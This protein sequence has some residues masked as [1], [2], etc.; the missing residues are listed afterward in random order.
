MVVV[1]RDV[2]IPD[3]LWRPTATRTRSVGW[4]LATLLVLGACGSGD[5]EFEVVLDGLNEPRGLWVLADG[6]L[7]VAEAG[8][9]AEGQEVREGPTANLA[10]TGSVT[11]VDTEGVRERVIEQLPYVFYN[12]TGVTTGPA[13]VVEMDGELYLLTGESEG[14]LARKL[15]R[16]TDPT[17][18]PEIMADLL[19]PPA[20]HQDPR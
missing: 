13:D 2:V 5:S 6:T 19:A 11:C 18:A 16:I 14:D 17:T 3:V 10:D 7:C 4:V 8:R 20:G 15:L 9:L 1:G 12:V